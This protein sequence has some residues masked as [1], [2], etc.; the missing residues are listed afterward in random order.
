M[1]SPKNPAMSP[2]PISQASSRG[3]IKSGP[4]RT[5]GAKQLLY[6][7][8]EEKGA[9]C[10]DCGVELAVSAALPNQGKI[11]YSPTTPF[12]TPMAGTGRNRYHLACPCCTYEISPPHLADALAARKVRVYAW[13]DPGEALTPVEGVRLLRATYALLRDSSMSPADQERIMPQLYLQALTDYGLEAHP[14]WMASQ[15]L[16]MR[17]RR[18]ASSL[19][20]PEL[21]AP[22]KS[23][24]FLAESWTNV[25]WNSIVRQRPIEWRDLRP[26]LLLVPDRSIVGDNAPW[27]EFQERGLALSEDA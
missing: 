2:P 1:T 11:N 5:G 26:F 14:I 3:G 22:S 10:E 13:S 24:S 21:P 12:I 9:Y 27:K 8:M 18:L 15:D 16:Q 23:N 19:L 17:V 20:L 7:V 25:H 6:E 4:T